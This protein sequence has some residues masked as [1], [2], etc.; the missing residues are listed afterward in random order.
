MRVVHLNP[1]AGVTAMVEAIRAGRLDAWT[2]RVAIG[3][4]PCNIEAY[5]KK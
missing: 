4:K 3:V 5:R 2:T 1:N